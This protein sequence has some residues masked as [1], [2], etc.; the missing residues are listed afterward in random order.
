MSYG[1][2]HGSVSHSVSL[3]NVAPGTPTGSSVD[4]GVV[5]SQP[6][7]VVI[8]GAGVSA[9]VVTLEGSLDNTNWYT[10][11]TTAALAAPG[12]FVA[13]ATVPARYLR[14]RVSTATVGGNITAQVA[15]GA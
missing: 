13:T 5:F 8:A 2:G 9:G 6:I 14:A 4:L 3:N 1:G 7:C 11:A 15:A 12:V 10:V